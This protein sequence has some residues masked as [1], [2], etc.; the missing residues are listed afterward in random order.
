[1]NAV[2]EIRAFN[3]FYTRFLGLVNQYYLQK[4]WSLTEV[5]V[6]YELGQT[7]NL[8]ASQL[9]NILPLDK[10]Y[11]SRL[12]KKLPQAELIEQQPSTAD[13]RVKQLSL[14]SNGRNFFQQLVDQSETQLEQQL[15]HL[16]TA[17]KT[18]LT[19]HFRSVRNL[20]SI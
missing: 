14:T 12:L 13:R 4:G 11:L 20:L 17:E 2:A 9:L 8:T 16:S 7:P 5:R 19:T 6:I 1:M 10:G 3:R 15:Q 18:E